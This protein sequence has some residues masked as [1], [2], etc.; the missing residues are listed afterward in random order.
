MHYNHCH[1]AT[2]HLQFIIIII[3]V[4][5]IIYWGSGR[6][7]NQILHGVAQYFWIPSVELAS[8][9]PPGTRG[10]GVATRFLG[11]SCTPLLLTF[12][13]VM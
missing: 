5:I 10:V 4:I 8:F 6:S 2:A 1:R 9:R 3:I 11:S 7:R 12:C 13:I